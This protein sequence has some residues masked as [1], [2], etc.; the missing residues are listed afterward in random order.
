MDVSTVR[1]LVVLFCSDLSDRP[2]FG[3][4]FTAVNSRNELL[5]YLSRINPRITTRLLNI[6]VSALKMMLTV[7]EYREVCARWFARMLAQKHKTT[8]CKSVRTCWT[9]LPQPP[10]SLDLANFLTSNLSG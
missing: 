7:L 10:Y 2:R 6:G 8:E 1:L 4:P 3:L 5:G 9:V